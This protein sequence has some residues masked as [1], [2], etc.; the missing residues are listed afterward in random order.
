MV[1]RE[2]KPVVWLFLYIRYLK[3]ERERDKQDAHVIA[4]K[5]KI[6]KKDVV[7]KNRGFASEVFKP[8]RDRL[9]ARQPRI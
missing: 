4:G 9:K 3:R 5:K 1:M 7:D 6:L 8:D 2:G